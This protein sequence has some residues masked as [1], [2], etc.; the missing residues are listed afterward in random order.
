[1]RAPESLGLPGRAPPLPCDAAETQQG[2]ERDQAH[3]KEAR[4]VIP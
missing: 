2:G 4:A 3:V 1:M